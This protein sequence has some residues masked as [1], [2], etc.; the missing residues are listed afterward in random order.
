MVHALSEAWRI[1]VPEGKLLDLRPRSATYPID[2]VTAAGRFHAG[3]F[4]GSGAESDDAAAD[5]VMRNAVED[6]R[7]TRL[8]DT[9][10][11]IEFCWDTVNEM[12]SHARKEGRIASVNP[13]Y[14]ELEKAYHELSTGTS[15]I[16][17]LRYRRPT[18]LAVYRKAE[19]RPAQKARTRNR[20][21][22]E[23]QEAGRQD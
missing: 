7:F 10:F 4:D 5:T 2:F 11:N 8:R 21:K 17:R 23:S 20:S 19:P 3:D 18:M 1:L 6:G 16:V 14:A 15:A 12:E 13:S 22:L 9:H